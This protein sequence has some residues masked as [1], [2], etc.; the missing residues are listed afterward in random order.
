MKV[1][2]TCLTPL[3]DE[4]FIKEGVDGKS[5]FSFQ[6]MTIAYVGGQGS[7]DGLFVQD[8]VCVCV[9]ERRERKGER[10]CLWGCSLCD[11]SLLPG[12]CLLV[13][14]VN[15]RVQRWSKTSTQPP[16]P[17]Q[18]PRSGPL[19]CRHMRT[20]I[21]QTHLTNYFPGLSFSLRLELLHLDAWRKKKNPV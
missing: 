9:H 8:C 4:R 6:W 20:L 14:S 11:S 15:R 1:A 18:E 16:Q 2:S 7:E 12:H 13:V 3:A 19:T 5:L 17:T 10:C 21:H